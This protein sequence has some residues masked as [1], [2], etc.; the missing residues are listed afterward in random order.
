[1]A[2][3]TQQDLD[4]LTAEVGQVQNDVTGVATTLTTVQT[5]L[6]TEIDNLAASQPDLD[7]S[8]LKAAL[9]QLDPAVQA[10]NAAATR[11]GDLSPEPAPVVDPTPVVPNGP[12][13]PTPT[14]A[15]P[16]PDP[17]PV[18][19]TPDPAPVDPDTPPDPGGV[20]TTGAR[21]RGSDTV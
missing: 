11:L 1:M 10:A 4:A 14:P 13:T 17:A 12:D 2:E 6:Q 21:R 19:P 3:V 15:D 7:I 8:G 9:D 16:T 5:Q 18:D 20:A